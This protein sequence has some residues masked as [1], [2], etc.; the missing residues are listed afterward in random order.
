MSQEWWT[1][2]ASDPSVA[3]DGD[4]L[5][6]HKSVTIKET[7]MLTGRWEAQAIGQVLDF[8]D[9]KQVSVQKEHHTH[10]QP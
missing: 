7:R 4:E 5:N 3:T 9:I 2:S 8:P 1:N 6:Q 10:T